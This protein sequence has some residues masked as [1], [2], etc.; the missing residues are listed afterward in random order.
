MVGR[1]DFAPRPT[2]LSVL[3]QIT[4]RALLSDPNMINFQQLRESVVAKQQQQ[5]APQEPRRVFEKLVPVAMDTAP[6][7]AQHA[8]LPN[9]IPDGV[10]EAVI[11]RSQYALEERSGACAA[12]AIYACLAVLYG[13]DSL[14]TV[15]YGTKS[16]RANSAHVDRAV[17]GGTELWKAFLGHQAEGHRFV[18]PTE[19][20]RRSIVPLRYLHSVEERFGIVG[21]AGANVRDSG[22]EPLCVVLREI[23]ERPDA[24][25]A[26][27]LTA[28]NASYALVVRRDAKT[29]ARSF[30]LIDSHPRR[31]TTA[32]ATNTAE[33]FYRMV[34]WAIGVPEA[35]WARELDPNTV[36]TVTTHQGRAAV[37]SSRVRNAPRDMLATS[38]DQYELCV[39]R[40][41]TG[42]VF[43]TRAT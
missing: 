34:L 21:R 16:V 12:I 43:G 28:F 31:G 6:A 3:A 9:R 27:V 40:P 26:A 24:L 8:P 11:G 1:P 35:A 19:I 37:D 36:A 22:L 30:V 14:F 38:S 23:V 13:A 33:Q 15:D 39:L 7:S 2:I 29:S 32:Y 18:C 41:S 25:V 4:D 42:V 17:A 20:L 5:P 10:V